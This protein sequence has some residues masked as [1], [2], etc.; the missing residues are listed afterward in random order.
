[1][2]AGSTA[3]GVNTFINFVGALNVIDIMFPIAP[4]DV[5]KSKGVRVVNQK[6]RI[7][8]QVSLQKLSAND[9]TEFQRATGYKNRGRFFPNS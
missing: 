1:M 7:K 5:D 2:F 6:A 9:R 3:E 8:I 4:R